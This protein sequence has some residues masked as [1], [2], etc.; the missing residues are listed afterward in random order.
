MRTAGEVL[1]SDS[2]LTVEVIEGGHQSPDAAGDQHV[3]TSAT[4]QVSKSRTAQY[5]D[6]SKTDASHVYDHVVIQGETLK[7]ARLWLQTFHSTT[8]LDSW[9]LQEFDITDVFH[10]IKFGQIYLKTRKQNA[11]LNNG[12]NQLRPAKDLSMLR[13]WFQMWYDHCVPSEHAH[14]SMPTRELLLVPAYWFDCAVIFRD[15]TKGRA[16]APVRYIGDLT[17]RGVAGMDIQDIPGP[18]L[19]D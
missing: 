7:A 1:G 3:R 5:I 9:A 18:I 2:D 12:E 16:Y 14:R 8:G 11:Q 10:V 13:E 4:F 17:P 6:L 19:S 15:V